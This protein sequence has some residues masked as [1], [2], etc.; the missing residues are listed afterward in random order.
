MTTS[1]ITQWNHRGDSV[2]HSLQAMFSTKLGRNST[3]QSS[4]TWSHN[5]ATST[6]GYLNTSQELADT[7][8]SAVNRGNA[9]F[10][11][12]H[13]FNV[14]LVYNLPTLTGRNGFL[15]GIAGG[16][17][18]GSIFNYAT[19]PHQTISGSVGNICPSQA[20]LARCNLPAS[21]P[22][23]VGTVGIGNPW[24]VNNAGQFGARANVISSQPCQVGGAQQWLN[25]SAYTWNGFKIGGYP[26]SGAGQCPGPGI[27][28]MDLSL[29][30]N[31]VLPFKGKKIFTEGTRLQLR[32]E[33]FNIFNHPMFRFNASGAG[34][35]LAFPATGTL[36]NGTVTGYIAPDNTIQGTVLTKGS[37]FG[38]PPFLSAIGNREIQYA[39]KF[40]F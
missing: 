27:E 29:N 9:D 36:P 21:D 37:T 40:I 3:V 7:Y 19:G 32:I 14:N 23:H 15:R 12:R 26:N 38:Q 16:W 5:I 2:Y 39:L 24:G 25:P 6:L 31:W 13:V 35:N 20:L 28:D 11:R 8:N 30:K 1:E 18:W 10:D 22:N 34:S 33:G 4:Y 17:E